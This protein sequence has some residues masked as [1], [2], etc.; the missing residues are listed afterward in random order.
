VSLSSR[1]AMEFW[2]SEGERFFGHYIEKYTES[3]CFLKS[4]E[5]ATDTFFSA[6]NFFSPKKQGDGIWF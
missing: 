1:I 3:L 4:K 2:L 5:N 6:S